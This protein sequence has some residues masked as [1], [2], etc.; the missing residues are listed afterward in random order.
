MT[1]INGLRRENPERR[2]TS[3]QSTRYCRRPATMAKFSCRS[4]GFSGPKWIQWGKLDVSYFLVQLC[5]S[6]SSFASA[7]RCAKKRKKKKTNTQRNFQVMQTPG[8]FNS[9]LSIPGPCTRLISAALKLK[10]KLL[11]IA[12]I[13]Y[14]GGRICRHKLALGTQRAIT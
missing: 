2:A 7:T 12:L 13:T 8:P 6:T 9:I 3:E 5:F 1:L 11:I 10:K 4:S 14:I